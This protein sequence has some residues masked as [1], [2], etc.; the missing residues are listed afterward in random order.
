MDAKA[1]GFTIPE[2]LLVVTIIGMLSVL[3][4]PFYR[5]FLIDNQLDTVVS[6]S[7]QALRRAQ[8]YARAGRTDSQWGVYIDDAA[9]QVTLFR[10]S[11]FAAR[12]TAY[13]DII[14]I[15][16]TMTPSGLTEVVFTRTTGLPNTTGTITF[17]AISGESATIDINSQGLI[18]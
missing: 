5:D 8:G 7:T 4:V 1:R 11:S 15:P 18:E 12:D 10:G 9:D 16:T 17:T 2:L 13:D 3:A 14:D 6:E